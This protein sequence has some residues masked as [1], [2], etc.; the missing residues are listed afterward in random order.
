MEHYSYY[1]K[2]DIRRRELS[3]ILS[4]VLQFYMNGDL[5]EGEVTC[6]WL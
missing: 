2:A 6:I 4:S 3:S 5:L 1:V